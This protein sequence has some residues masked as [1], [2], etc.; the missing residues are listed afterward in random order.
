MKKRLIL[1]LLILFGISSITYAGIFGR[2][3]WI[4][5]ET[6][7]EQ[8]PEIGGYDK[9]GRPWY[10]FPGRRPKPE[11]KPDVKPNVV[12]PTDLSTANVLAAAKRAKEL[13]ALKDELEALK[14]KPKP[15]KKKSKE[16]PLSPLLPIGGSGLFSILL[17]LGYQGYKFW[18]NL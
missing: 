11:P 6:K 15:E 13:K 4:E 18:S 7:I 14:N 16:E 3:N 2:R 10:I 17:A 5:V 8:E 12:I 9:Y 1:G